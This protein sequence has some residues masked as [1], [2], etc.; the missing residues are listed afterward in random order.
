MYDVINDRTVYYIARIRDKAD[1]LLARELKEHGLHGLA[2]SHGDIMVALFKHRQLTMGDL[3]RIIDRDKSTV[4]GLVDKL[5]RLE[6][7][8]KNPDPGDQRVQMVS[9]TE[10]GGRLIPAFITISIRLQEAFSRDLTDREKET[11]AGLLK[12]VDE[13][14]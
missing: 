9:L 6:Y 4:T 14:W 8:E 5:V 13:A 7:L 12:K 11:L 10:K 2:P 3:A 1:R